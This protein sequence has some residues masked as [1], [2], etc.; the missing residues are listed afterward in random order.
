MNGNSGRIN[1]KYNFYHKFFNEEI[2]LGFVLF[3]IMKN[4][5]SMR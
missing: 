2:L 4:L 5:K 1:M 3:H